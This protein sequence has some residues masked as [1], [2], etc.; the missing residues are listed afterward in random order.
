MIR[1]FSLWLVFAAVS[2]PQQTPTA[3]RLIE[4]AVEIHKAEAN[5]KFTWREEQEQVHSDGK[6]GWQPVFKRS[7]DVIMLQGDT[8][9]KLVLLDGKPLNAKTQKKVDADL[10][11]TREER[12]KQ[13]KSSVLRKRLS[14]GDTEQLLK[15]FDNKLAGEE[16]VEGRATWKVESEPKVGI[17]AVTPAEKSAMS[18]RR[19]TWFDKEAG[20]PVKRIDLTIRVNDGFQPGTEVAMTYA[21]LREQ[22][23]MTS[24]IARFDVKFA[25]VVRVR[26]EDRHQMLD[27]KRFEVESSLKPE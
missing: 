17:T 15:L 4:R 21:P 5:V 12:K 8:Y 23:L 18:S 20:V 25:K 24:L 11:K 19:T 2:F 27:Y 3:Q 13:Q 26:G 14:V 1:L 22:W 7:F 16:V 9:K 6:G 10:A